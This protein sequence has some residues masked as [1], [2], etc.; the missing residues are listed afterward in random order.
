MAEKKKYRCIGC[1]AWTETLHEIIHGHGRRELCVEYM[2]Q[3]PVCIHCHNT[4]HGKIN[5]RMNR[6]NDGHSCVNTPY[7]QRKL[8]DLVGVDFY[9][10]KPA[11]WNS[12]HK[13]LEELEIVFREFLKGREVG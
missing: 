12:Y 8:C 9:V 10:L 6:I 4:A 7:V 5:G 13:T 1:E 11:V 2:I 3:V